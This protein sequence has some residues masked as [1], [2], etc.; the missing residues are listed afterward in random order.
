ME[1]LEVILNNQ[2]TEIPKAHQL[3]DEL[4]VQV[5]LSP[6][7]CADL[8]VA[9]EEHLTNVINYGYSPGQPGQIA[10]RLSAAPDAM[11]V[12]IEDDA[13]PFNPLLAPPVDVHQPLEERPIGGLGIHMIRQ[14]TDDL[15]YAAR[16][17]HN[18]LTLIKRSPAP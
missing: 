6:R 13:R 10:V 18:V 17:G 16:D 12:E 9:L 4:A 2:R 8:H 14:L 11:R 1:L 15:R 5:G 7:V 3:L